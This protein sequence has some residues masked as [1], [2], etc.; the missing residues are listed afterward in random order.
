MI[1]NDYFE[2]ILTSFCYHNDLF[3]QSIIN[4]IYLLSNRTFSLIFNQFISVQARARKRVDRVETVMKRFCVTR[5]FICNSNQKL[6]DMIFVR[7][8]CFASGSPWDERGENINYHNM[9]VSIVIF[10][11]QVVI[12]G[13]QIVQEINFSRK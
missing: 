12:R 8:C 6:R 3:C 10:N 11:G 2:V 4:L 13:I 9:H 1:F 7:Y 5:S